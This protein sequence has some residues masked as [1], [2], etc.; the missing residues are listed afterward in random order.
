MRKLIK[1]ITVPILC[2]IIVAS[3][4]FIS[5]FHSEGEDIV[6]VPR[7]IVVEKTEPVVTA[8][9]EETIPIVIEETEGS[10]EAIA[11]MSR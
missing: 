9:Q 7:A 11:K 2:G 5:E 8:L 3:S 1:V 10:T 4:F 6:A